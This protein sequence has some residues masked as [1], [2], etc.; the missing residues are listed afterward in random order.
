[1]GVEAIPLMGENAQLVAC[2]RRQARQFQEANRQW[3]QSLSSWNMRRMAPS[4]TWK[5]KPS[6]R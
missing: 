4:R 5:G 6:R 1:M 2:R 3:F